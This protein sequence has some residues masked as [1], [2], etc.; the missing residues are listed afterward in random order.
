M[1]TSAAEARAAA[2]TRLRWELLRGLI[3]KDLK[4]KYKNS[5]LG[6]LWSLANPLLYLAVFSFVF[7]VAFRNGI[8]SFS[9]FLM[10]GLL[11][12]NFF[13]N[14]VA[15][16]TSSVV[17][18]SNLVK[19]V[20]FPLPVLPLSA[21]GFAG[22]H[23]VLQLGVLFAFL[24]TF[25]YPFFGAQLLLLLPAMIVVIVFVAGLSLLVAALNVRY[26]DVGFIVEVVLLAGFWAVP[27]VYPIT[28]VSAKLG[29]WHIYGAYLINPMT[30]VILTFQRAIY[31]RPVITNTVT[32]AK[33]QVLAASGYRFYVVHLAL[34]FVVAVA[35]FGL[36]WW[37]FRRRQGDFAEEL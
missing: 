4:V 22:T 29:S 23:F 18:N 11:V 36:G 37:V 19:K 8:P 35:F 33:Q 12:W 3:S 14:A 20:R 34:A 15:M 24:L 6:F 28:T 10:S 16:A 13:A 17:A 5:A 27:V 30:T 1:T 26:R 32:H 25:G 9:A 7:G 2:Q 21:V 31:R